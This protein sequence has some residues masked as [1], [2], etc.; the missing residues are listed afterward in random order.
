M[1]IGPTGCV[2]TT[3]HPPGG[4]AAI[5]GPRKDATYRCGQC[6]DQLRD[7]LGLELLRARLQAE[8]REGE[9]TISTLDTL[10]MEL[11]RSNSTDEADPL[12]TS[13]ES[14]EEERETLGSP[15]TLGSINNLGLLL[16][17][18]GDLAAAEPQYREAL[19][20]KRETLGDRH[21]HTLS[22]IVVGPTWVR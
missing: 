12:R 1:P 22:S 5:T 6:M 2:W 15:N 3:T 9:A 21:P 19:E 10:A 14:L 7:S 16:K 13:R 4:V 11:H 8:R 17:A 18:K 20:G